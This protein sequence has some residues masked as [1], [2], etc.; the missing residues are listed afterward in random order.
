MEP[1]LVILILSLTIP[2]ASLTQA[3]PR[4]EEPTPP[5]PKEKSE[6]PKNRPEERGKRRLPSAP[7]P[8]L[9]AGHPDFA[10]MIE[11]ALAPEDQIQQR[12]EQWPRYQQLDE[13]GRAEMRQG[14]HRL[15][16]RLREE[17]LEEATTRGWVI[18][19]EREAEFL[20]AYWAGRIRI[21]QAIRQRA[22]QEWKAAMDEAARRLEKEFF[23]SSPAR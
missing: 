15:R 1:R 12:L 7:K 22:E 3:A 10:R 6:F 2:L 20:R 4:N 19:P 11:A 21:E 23:T 8:F 5:P 9:M 18:P 17:A 13:R 14:F 16:R